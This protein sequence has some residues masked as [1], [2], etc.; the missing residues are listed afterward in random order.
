MKG[1]GV[2]FGVLFSIDGSC[3]LLMGLQSIGCLGGIWPPM[4]DREMESDSQVEQRYKCG[5]PDSY[6]EIL[7]MRKAL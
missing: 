1:D 7:V 2:Y 5:A 3:F 4:Y 6:G